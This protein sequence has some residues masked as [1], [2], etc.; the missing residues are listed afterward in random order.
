MS[1]KFQKNWRKKIYYENKAVTWL[2]WN[3][4]SYTNEGRYPNKEV[5]R[6]YTHQK[7]K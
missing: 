3:F 4:C 2:I 6:T 1:L 5:S 7:M